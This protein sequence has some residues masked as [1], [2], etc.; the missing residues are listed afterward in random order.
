MDILQIVAVAC[1]AG[2]LSLTLKPYRPEL[3]VLVG[4]AAGMLIFLSV[5][6][7]LAGIFSAFGEI[8]QKSGINIKY[9]QLVIKIIGIAYITQLAGALLKDCGESALALKAEFAGKIAIMLMAMPIIS[10][11]LDIITET[12]GNF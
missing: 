2:I 11:F 3:S 7:S 10:G 8:M 5:V 6:D 9:F 12:L 4:V 1:V